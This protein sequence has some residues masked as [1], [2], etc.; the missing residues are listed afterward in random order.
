MKMNNLTPSRNDIFAIADA[1]L[2]GGKNYPLSVKISVSTS[3]L[4]PEL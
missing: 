2:A 4:C 1:F 3:L